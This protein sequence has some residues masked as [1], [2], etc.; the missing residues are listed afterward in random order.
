[1]DSQEVIYEKIIKKLES[2][3]EKL[4]KKRQKKR[5]FTVLVGFLTSE[6][7]GFR[8]AIDVINKQFIKKKQEDFYRFQKTTITEKIEIFEA[9][10][11]SEKEALKKIKDNSSNHFIEEFENKE[12]ADYQLIN[13]EVPER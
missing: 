5:K 13:T 12:Y 4:N 9:E 3:I 1:M 2:K 8:K 6:I 10:A 11:V 7:R